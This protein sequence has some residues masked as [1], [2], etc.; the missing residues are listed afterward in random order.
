MTKSTIA[1]I[2]FLGC[3]EAGQSMASSIL[4]THEDIQI[5]A[6]DIRGQTVS[7]SDAAG[8]VKYLDSPR[9]LARQAR[10]I[11]SVVTADQSHVAGAAIAPFLGDEHI[12]VDGNS[13]SPGTKASTAGIIRKQGAGYVDMA[14]MAP[15]KGKGHRTPL[16]LAGDK[17]DDIC[18][19][20]D[21]LG[22]HYEWEGDEVGAASV[23]KMLR[24]VLIKGMESLMCES[25]SAAVP[26]GLNE[27]ILESV[28]KTLGIADMPALADYMLE[29][30]AVHGRR[31]AAEMLEAAKTFDELGLSSDMTAAIARHQARIADMNLAAQFD[32]GIP[33]D[34]RILAPLMQKHQRS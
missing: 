26:L 7:E 15:V 20:C 11:I 33:Q 18:A 19:I 12:F 10:L 22:C 2:G 30:V 14:I 32:D 4:R 16:L 31:R 8:A 27:R 21:R 1:H 5:F 28:G 24:S 29:R 17:A 13:V 23:V 6:Y 9:C 3:G 25:M 34:H